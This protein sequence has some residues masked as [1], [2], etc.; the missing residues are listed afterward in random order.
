MSDREFC[1]V[2]KRQAEAFQAGTTDPEFA[3]HVF[4][5]QWAVN[6]G[7]SPDVYCPAWEALNLVANTSRQEAMDILFGDEAEEVLA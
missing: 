3:K 6:V 7:A 2:C 4:M 5:A 1:E